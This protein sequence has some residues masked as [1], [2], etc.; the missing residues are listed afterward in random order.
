MVAFAL[1]SSDDG[2][3]KT[4][5]FYEVSAIRH[6][7]YWGRGLRFYDRAMSSA[8][9]STDPVETEFMNN[10]KIFPRNFIANNMNRFLDLF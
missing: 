5:E 9:Y 2:K 4:S 7:E 10:S 8:Q 6:S 3:I 1:L